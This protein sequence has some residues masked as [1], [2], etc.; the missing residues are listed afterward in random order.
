MTVAKIR[1]TVRCPACG[2]PPRIRTV[3]NVDRILAGDPEDIVLSY[4]C[5]RKMR[6]GSLCNEPYEIRVKHFSEAG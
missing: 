4:Q 6:D 2:A 1:L 5:A 3:P